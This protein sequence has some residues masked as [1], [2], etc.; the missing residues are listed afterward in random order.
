M[1]S[2]TTVTRTIRAPVSRV[3]ETVGDIRNYQNAIP[4]IVRVEVLTDGPPDVGTR[5]R[6]TRLMNGKEATTELEVTEYVKDERIRLV[7]D[8]G[9]TIWDSLFSVRA[10]DEGTELTLWMEGRPY[11][12]V[13]KLMTPLI[14]KMIR[15]ALEGDLDAVKAYCES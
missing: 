11:K 8:A 9:G 10:V 15:K 6:E 13:P 7:A 3:F 4:E 2:S 14:M 1:A 5:F 12:V